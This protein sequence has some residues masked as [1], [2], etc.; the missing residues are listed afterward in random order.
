MTELSSL[1]NVTKET[2]RRDLEEMDEKGLLTRTHGGAYLARVGTDIPVFSREI[3]YLKGKELIGEK[4]FNLVDDG[5]TIFLDS[6]TTCL[7]IAETIKTKHNL[8]VLTN[9]IKIELSLANSKDIKIISTGGILRT[10]SLSHV[11]HTVEKTLSEFYADKAFVSCSGVHLVNG[12]TDSNDYEAEVR[13][14][15]LQHSNQKILV[16]D[17]TKFGKTAFKQ[18]CNLNEINVVI[19]DKK[20][21]LD[22]KFCDLFTAYNIELI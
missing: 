7:K 18:I 9:S 14:T 10:S 15:M 20:E 16:A 3:T 21:E 19:I 11:G 4:C 5:D 8:T 17:I 2:I 1:L 12:I 22:P 13:K 6:S